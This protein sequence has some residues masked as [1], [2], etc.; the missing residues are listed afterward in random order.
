[1]GQRKERS[2][3]LTEIGIPEVQGCGK[4]LIWLPVDVKSDFKAPI[5]VPVLTVVKRAVA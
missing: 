1:V 5:A 4:W 3:F 2:L